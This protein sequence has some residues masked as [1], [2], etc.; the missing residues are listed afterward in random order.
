VL[1]ILALVGVGIVAY[2][3]RLFFRNRRRWFHLAF[4]LL[5]VVCVLE[6]A[7]L[8]VWSVGVGLSDTIDC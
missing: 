3:S 2:F 4:V 5:L 8:F 1:S 6:Y 7:Y